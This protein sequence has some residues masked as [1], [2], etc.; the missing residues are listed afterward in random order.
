[1]TTVR[2]VRPG[3][4]STVQDMGRWGYEH[5][6]VMVGGAQDEWA[7]AWANRLLGNG[8]N[9]PA[10]EITALGPDLEVMAAGPLA[11]AG[12]DLSATV[13][14]EP[15]ISGTGR[16]VGVGTRIRFGARRRG[17]R[18][19]LAFPGGVAV[20]EVLG[21]R[22]TDLVSGIGGLSGRAMIAGDLLESNDIGGTVASTAWP[23]MRAGHV[24]RVMP[25]VR[26]NRFP[27]SSYFQLLTR[28]FAVSADSNAIGLRLTGE[29]VASPRGDW[30][31][32]GMAIGSIECPPS[33][34]LLVL[35]KGRGSLGGYPPLAHVIRA[36]WPVM[37][38]LAPG[39]RVIFEG[40]DT[41]GARAALAQA[42]QF[43][44][45]KPDTRTAA[46]PFKGWLVDRDRY[47]R[48]LPNAG[49][50]V[51]QGQCVACIAAAGEVWEV[52][53]GSAGVLEWVRPAGQLINAGDE[54]IAMKGAGEAYDGG[55]KLRHGGELWGVENGGRRARFALD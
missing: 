9:Q 27:A 47:G 30:P 7:L 54:I 14:G 16:T 2:V 38:Q 36:D 24:L 12:A 20:P 31:S 22:T 35:M 55:F 53:S 28:E 19:Y 39:D 46:M 40:V 33:G 34:H 5:W 43:P 23:T 15:W 21:S 32:E 49:D 6:G 18:A 51:W 11:L 4:L 42:W 8:E 3:F 10:L 44:D 52:L 29:P 48:H 45:G 17:F 41:E 50:W 25:G 13:D 1:M 37:A 26:R